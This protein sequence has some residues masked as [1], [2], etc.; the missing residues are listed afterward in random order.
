MRRFLAGSAL[1]LV[2]LAT[3]A[4][5]RSQAAAPAE[6]PPEIP[7]A[8]MPAGAV[9]S[10]LHGSR[11]RLDALA[12]T[13]DLRR[14]EERFRRMNLVALGRNP[15]DGRP[16][17]MTRDESPAF[18]QQARVLRDSLGDGPVD[19]LG[20]RLA[21]LGLA[22]LVDERDTFRV[23][24][25]ADTFRGE[26]LPAG[27]LEIL[28]LTRDLPLILMH[29]GFVGAGNRSVLPAFTLRTLL[30][31]RWNIE[32]ERPADHGFAV[33]ERIAWLEFHGRYRTWAS[34]PERR[35]ALQE[36]ATVRPGY[37][38]ADALAALARTPPPGSIVIREEG[39]D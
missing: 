6:R 29:H 33:A 24:L 35:T 1:L 16:I 36:L 39:D 31:A 5:C 19:T 2:A 11:A 25:V 20:E 23:P 4:A 37:P 12:W 10:V 18:R 14:L 13:D 9:E 27:V 8:T 32:T 38:L 17:N 21:D 7:A 34:L 26:T 3:L 15:E 22:A 28:A 30:R